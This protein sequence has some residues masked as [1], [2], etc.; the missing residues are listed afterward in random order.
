MIRLFIVAGLEAGGDVKE[1]LAF[2]KELPK[3]MGAGRMTL[4]EEDF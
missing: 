2:E 4:S 1:F 3:V